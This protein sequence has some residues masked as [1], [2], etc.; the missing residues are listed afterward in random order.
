[1]SPSS[2]SKFNPSQIYLF[3]FNMSQTLSFL[4]SHV[5][6][7]WPIPITLFLSANWRW[8]LQQPG[9]NSS[10]QWAVSFTT[11]TEF[12]YLFH[13]PTK[14]KMHR[15]KHVKSLQI[16]KRANRKLEEA[17]QRAQLSRTGWV[18]VEVCST[19]FWR[20][21]LLPENKSEIGMNWIFNWSDEN[22]SWF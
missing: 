8:K 17:K 10:T 7:A 5:L 1:M 21:Y 16:A 13:L 19:N 3:N 6:V 2:I 4:P 20:I 18:P 15:I 12:F 11:C 22:R 14:T 9:T